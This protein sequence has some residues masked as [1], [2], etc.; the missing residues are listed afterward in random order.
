M[1]K[2]L[3]YIICIAFFAVSCSD[4]ITAIT[5]PDSPENPSDDENM[6]GKPV[7]FVCVGKAPQATTRSAEDGKDDVYE[8]EGFT[9]AGKNPN[10]DKF[11]RFNITMAKK[12]SESESNPTTVSSALYDI[13]E[14][15][16]EVTPP[17]NEL[18][19]GLEQRAEGS[20]EPGLTS[21]DKN[22]V[23]DGTLVP[24][25]GETPLYWP[26]NVN[27]YGFH[28]VS[29]EGELRINQNDPTTLTG[30]ETE[31]E[32]SAGYNFW[33]NDYLE[34]YGYIPGRFDVLNNY[35]YRTTNKWY[36][37]NQ[38][39]WKGALA[40]NNITA[41]P[42]DPEVYKRVPLYMVHKR[43]W[44]TVI[45]KAGNGIKRETLYY[46]ATG[47]NSLTSSEIYSKVPDG[48][49][50]EFLP[51]KPWRQPA[52]VNYEADKN[53]AAGTESSTALHAI[54][55]PHSYGIDELLTKIVLNGQVF[56]YAPNNDSEHAYEKY[57]LE[58]GKHLIITANLTTD[59]IVLI[60]AHLE[61]WE[62]V[63]YSSICDD[64]GQ[65]G[66]PFII[67]TRDQLRAFLLNTTKYNKPG[68][69]ALIAAKVMDLEKA[70]HA[71][72][73]LEEVL[74][75]GYTYPQGTTETASNWEPLPLYCTLNLAGCKISSA[76]QLFSNIDRYG[77][78]VNGTVIIT[79][80]RGK[81]TNTTDG[82]SS[83]DT[84]IKM[85]AAICEKNHGT[86]EQIS[87]TVSETITDNSVYAT[88]GGIAAINYGHILSCSNDLEVRGTT[89]YIGGIA[90]QSLQTTYQ[91]NNQTINGVL[92]IIDHCTVNGRVGIVENED[93]KTAFNNGN[94]NG[95]GGIV[96]YA[97]N[98]VT[99]N[100]FNY[101]I[102]LTYQNDPKFKN[103][104]QAAA[105][106]GNT[107]LAQ[108][109][110]WPTAVLNEIGTDTNKN[111][112]IYSGVKFS[113]VIDCQG[114]LKDIITSDKNNSGA[115]YRIARDF[116]VSSDWGYG[117]INPNSS[118]KE[119]N[120]AFELDGNDKTIST[121]GKMLFTNIR[122][123]I[124][125]LTVFSKLD[126]IE[127][128]TAQNTESVS[129]FAYSVQASS[130]N[131]YT[132]RLKNIKIKM[133]AG[134]KIIA[135][136][137]SGLVVMAYGGASIED[138]KVDAQLQVRLVQPEGDQVLNNDMR[139]YCGGIVS[140]ASTVTLSGCH[141]YGSISDDESEW[142][143]D[144][145]QHLFFRGGIVGGVVFD[146][147]TGDSNPI[148]VI[149][150]CASWWGEEKRVTNPEKWS[151]AGSIIGSQYWFR[152][153]T[154]QD[155]IADGSC[156]G[157]W[158]HSEFQPIGDISGETEAESKVG[159]RN[160]IQPDRD[161]L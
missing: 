145:D 18:T 144:L 55:E 78:L 116:E 138:C 126:V 133:A 147:R 31:L 88:Q 150:D 125:D 87:V 92:P 74:V 86:I 15:E 111:Q 24:A 77:S 23:S 120:I 21:T 19:G 50:D 90:G 75:K 14:L 104:V 3:L 62:D 152:G 72:A 76:G 10:I 5:E 59:R 9:Y 131:G 117:V 54:V 42:D 64:Y 71:D 103:I 81:D 33:R 41:L 46:S 85:P 40:A 151:P 109:N 2:H 105:T 56:T 26:D 97:E 161:E 38:M 82:T 115:K 160:S 60:T 11:Y 8:V 29:N 102:P 148:T 128:G 146:N 108:N 127:P 130:E 35:N 36:T 132:G 134:K 84:T 57:N 20:L 6:V 70:M 63:T 106:T 149:N 80:D 27:E 99:N 28:V 44:I 67:N 7:Q 61:D 49:A 101:G 156:T 98:R 16:S 114:E 39:V 158:W 94:N 100:T 65:Q 69:V 45:L 17:T 66:D 113:A 136:I 32:A 93:V 4:T 47:G 96:G 58:A 139:L 123:Y 110:A 121:N 43:A 157:N 154:Q 52:T 25:E 34:G 73:N 118:S 79:G 122:G 143:K 142:I 112:N 119:Y 83:F 107:L 141:F 12:S 30:S 140:Q 22:Y 53:G 155:G 89:G 91:V 153:T 48:S 37:H 124:H 129:P 95:V 137:P 159:K 68:N 135:P 1:I 13:K 51:I